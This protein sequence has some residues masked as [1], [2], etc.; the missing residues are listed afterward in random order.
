PWSALAAW[1][2]VRRPRIA[3]VARRGAVNRLAWH[4]SGPV[5]V[6]RNLF[7]RLRSPE[8]LAADLDWLYGW[9]VSETVGH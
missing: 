7:L 3:K 4:A 5:A 8:R 6:A 1:E 2:K 9:Q